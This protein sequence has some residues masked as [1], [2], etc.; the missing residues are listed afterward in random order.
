MKVFKVLFVALCI[1]VLAGCSVLSNW[2]PS[3]GPSTSSVQNAAMDDS[4]IEVIPLNGDVI[5]K[6]NASSK[7]QLFSEVFGN[8]TRDYLIRPGDVLEIN[9][10]EASPALLFGGATFPGMAGSSGSRNSVIPEQMVNQDGL[11]YMP[12][13][14]AIKAQ[15]KTLT[16]LESEILLAIRGKANFPQVMVRMSKNTS[17]ITVVGE[18]NN[19]TMLPLTPKGERIL[20]AIA[21]AGGVKQPINKVTLQLSRE[22]KSHTIALESVIKDAKQN[23]VL[24]RGDVLTAYFQPYSFTS[25]GATGKNEEIQFEANGIT[26]AQALGRMGGILD[27]RANAKGVF[28]FRFEDPTLAKHSKARTPDGKVPVIYQVDMTNPSTYFLAQSFNLKNKDVVYVSNAPS[29]ELQKFLNILISVVYP[30]V[31]VGIILP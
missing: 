22:S 9:V 30:L 10:W 11:I 16:Q 12:F 26:L 29:V 4:V 6:I 17:A 1:P 24:Q 13:A 19:S 23:I 31:N 15:G 18:V 14:G 3:S 27:N 25:L 2:L 5:S 20:D 7:Q 21:S 8:A 28:I